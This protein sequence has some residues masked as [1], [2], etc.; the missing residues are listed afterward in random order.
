MNVKTLRLGL[1]GKDVSQS[2]SPQ[3]HTFILGQFGVGCEYES[4]SVSADGFDGAIRRLLGDFDGF[5]VTIPYKRDVLGY[6]DDVTGDAMEYGAIN[7]VICAQRK[8]YNTD[9]VGFMQMLYSAGVNVE[10][11]KVLIVGGGGSA[12]SI[13]VALKQAGASL[14]MYQRNKE[15]LLETCQELSISPAKDCNQGGF[16]ILINATGVGM[17]DTVGISPVELSAFDGAKTAIDLIYRPAQSEFLR[18][19]DSLGLQ[20]INGAAMLF[21]QAY[22]ADCLYLGLQPDHAQADEFYQKF[23]QT[24]ID[25]KE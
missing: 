24:K 22:Y 1:I 4:I 11:Q 17:H 3:I 25:C 21:Y 14:F 6:L 10:N 19:A 13:A 8:G 20:T 12:R 5:N 23:S 9:G 15:K 7:T 2:V 16:D 18:Q